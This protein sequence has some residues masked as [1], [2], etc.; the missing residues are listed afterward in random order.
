MKR[1]ASALYV[2]LGSNR[3]FPAAVH[4]FHDP[5]P[6]LSMQIREVIPR[7]YPLWTEALDGTGELTGCDFAWR[8][9]NLRVRI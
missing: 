6:G 9:I 3:V 5:L 8:V 4:R 2:D 7:S 1:L